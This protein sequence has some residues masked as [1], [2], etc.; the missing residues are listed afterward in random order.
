MNSRIES[1]TNRMTNSPMLQE[2]LPNANGRSVYDILDD[3]QQ[4]NPQ[5]AH[6][7]R[8]NHKVPKA[9]V[10]DRVEYILD[11]VKGKTV[12]DIGCAGTNGNCDLFK[13]IM[14]AAHKAYGIDSQENELTKAMPNV[15]QFNIDE[16]LPRDVFLPLFYDIELV[17]AGELLEHLSNP[18][19]LLGAIRTAYSHADLLITVPNAFSASAIKHIQK[20]TECVNI[21]HT[22]W[23]SWR[24]LKTLVERYGYSV[25]EVKWYN[26]KPLI[27]EGIV[28][29]CSKDEGNVKG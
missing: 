17:I 15:E 1:A 6:A 2:M 10:V 21:D 7:K 29:L 18:G 5:T 9:E 4:N 8:M 14:V 25:D 13:K 19:A 12:L 23:F 16:M 28:F 26:G 3:I 27:A 24:T 11:A 22:C 20:G